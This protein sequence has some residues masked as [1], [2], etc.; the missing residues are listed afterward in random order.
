MLAGGFRIVEMSQRY[1]K[2][3]RPMTWIST[4]VAEPT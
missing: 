3:P 2:G 4:G 1:V